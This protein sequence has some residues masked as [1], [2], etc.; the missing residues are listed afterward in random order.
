MSRT[1]D[2]H[3]RTAAA[4]ARWTGLACEAT[5]G[6]QT[7]SATIYENGFQ[8]IFAPNGGGISQS[9]MQMISVTKS[10]LTDFADT[11]KYPNGEPPKNTTPTVIRGVEAFVLNVNERDGIFYITTG[12]P[13]SLQ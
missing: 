12:D 2:A 9:G 5:I 4:Q 3:D 8:D 1:T 13:A 7:V 6:T 10:L 11:V